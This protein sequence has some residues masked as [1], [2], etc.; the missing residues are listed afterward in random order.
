VTLIAG[1][2][3]AYASGWRMAFVLTAVLPFIGAAAWVQTVFSSG[4]IYSL[5]LAHTCNVRLADVCG[6]V[7]GALAPV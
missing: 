7:S 6:T 1:F 5:S 2:V 3:I 4:A